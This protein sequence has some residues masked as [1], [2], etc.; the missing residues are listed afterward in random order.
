MQPI[1]SFR[2]GGPD[3]QGKQGTRGG[4][5]VLG[6]WTVTKAESLRVGDQERDSAV[7]RLSRHYV[8]GRLTAAE[9]DERTTLALKARTDADL[10]A[11]FADLPLLDDVSASRRRPNRSVGPYRVL[12]AI[13]GVAAIVIG[14]LVVMQVLMI[15]A[16]VGLALAVSRA[17]FGWGPGPRRGSGRPGW[18]R[19]VG[20]GRGW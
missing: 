1:D 10:R 13:A 18:Q 12:R 11:L 17:L 4:H 3:R 8:D 7:A 5:R 19:R 6:G 16:I 15:L 20:C 9:H 14:F 2:P